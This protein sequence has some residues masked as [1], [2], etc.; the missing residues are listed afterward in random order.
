MTAGGWRIVAALAVSQTVGYGV[1]SY[2]FS[3]LLTPMQ[4]ALHADPAT[5][6]GALTT[7]LL[8]G[9]AAAV[10]VGRWLDRHGG[11]AL[12]TAGSVAATL[13][14]VAWSQVQTV[15]QLY[16]VWL[17]IGVASAAVLYEAAFAVVVTWFDDR[18]RGSALLAVTVVAGFAS[19]IFFPLTGALVEAYGWRTALLVLAAVHG[20]LT[21]PLHLLVR[22]PPAGIPAHRRP[23][24]QRRGPVGAALRDRA[25]WVLVAVFVAQTSAVAVVS[26][27][28]VAYLRD[29][30]HPPAFAAMVAGLLGVLSVAGR[31]ATTG[32]QRRW[33]PTTVVAAV[34]LLQSAGAATLALAGAATAGAVAGVLAFG[35]GFGVATIARP[36]LL[37]D[38]YGTA[39]F[40]TIAGVLAVPLTVVKATAP[41]AASIVRGRAGSYTPVVFVIAGACLLAALGLLTVGPAPD[42]RD[43]AQ[44]SGRGRGEAGLPTGAARQ[45]VAQ[46]RTAVEDRP[47]GP[48]PVE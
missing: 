38:R 29:L 40:A 37:A 11:R 34:F 48:G 17:G 15:L 19:S 6:T 9:A 28:L 32:A 7:A 5:I 23:P 26:V 46:R 13:L 33:P 45:R 36:A 8:A 2:A 12:M 31:L 3:V 22:R 21:V 10:P 25:Y 35:I 20:A 44:A 39:G 30:G 27:H 1:L 24:P 16:L 4:E 14:V 18:R 41:L 43:A 47:A 42:G